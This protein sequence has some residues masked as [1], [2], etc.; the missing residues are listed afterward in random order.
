MVAKTLTSV[1]PTALTA[2][3]VDVT[4]ELART[5]KG[6]AGLRIPPATLSCRQHALPWS[7]P[8]KEPEGAAPVQSNDFDYILFQR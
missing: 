7:E 3:V 2:S 6:T 4:A 8:N 5:V 1:L